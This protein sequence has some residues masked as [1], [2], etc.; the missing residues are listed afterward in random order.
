MATEE[1]PC[2]T[3]TKL[4]TLHEKNSVELGH[5]YFNDHTCR[6]F[7]DSIADVMKNELSGK[8]RAGRFFSVICD[9]STD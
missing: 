1:I 7:T 6:V 5:T 2:A 3:F 8:L 9:G 4:C